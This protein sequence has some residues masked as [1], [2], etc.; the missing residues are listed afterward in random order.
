VT[1]NFNLFRLIFKWSL[2]LSLVI[3]PL[4][5]IYGYLQPWQPASA[6]L[7][8]YVGQ[9][10]IMVGFSYRVQNKTSISSRTYILFPSVFNEPKIVTIQQ[11]NDSN[12]TVAVSLAGFLLFVGWGLVSFIGTWWFWLRGSGKGHLTRHS[13]GTPNGAP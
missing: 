11:I 3:V 4:V 7:S 13:S 6:T 9:S 5:A 10:P 1:S 2:P 12:P 8:S